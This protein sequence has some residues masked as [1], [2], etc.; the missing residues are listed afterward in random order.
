MNVEKI[1]WIEHKG[2]RIINLDF[3]GGPEV[4]L[5]T[6][7]KAGEVIQH[8][9]ENSVRSLIDVTSVTWNA[10]SVKALKALAK[11]DEPYVIACA[12]VGVTGMKKI[13]L[14][15]VKR[16]S[17]REFMLF[18]DVVSAMDWLATQ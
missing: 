3:S 13:L 8:E 17:G 7:R 1:H 18:D 14:S 12:V 10:E 16:F 9:P 11:G 4:A 5:G 2:K 6:M 15:A